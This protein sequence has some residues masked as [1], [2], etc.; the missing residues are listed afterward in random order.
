MEAESAKAEALMVFAESFALWRSASGD[1]P[2]IRILSGKLDSLLG[3]FGLGLI[4]GTGDQFDP[5]KHEACAAD[6]DP[7]RPE[8]SVLEVIRPGFV[9]DGEILRCATVVVNRESTD[10]I[11]EIR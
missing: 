8:N 9:R 4:D 2:E 3:Q 10:A 7:Q 11:G 1:S 6:Y 5:A